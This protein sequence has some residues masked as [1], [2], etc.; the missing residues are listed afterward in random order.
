MM[1]AGKTAKPVTERNTPQQFQQHLFVIS[2]SN[3]ECTEVLLSLPVQVQTAL[4]FYRE[5][6]IKTGVLNK[7]TGTMG[8]RSLP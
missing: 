8:V 7:G 1:M 2:T 3:S 5:G 4:S 6:S